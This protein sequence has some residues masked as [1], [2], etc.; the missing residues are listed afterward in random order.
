[1][2]ISTELNKITLV[3]PVASGYA[4]VHTIQKVTTMEVTLEESFITESISS[5]EL[6]T[7]GYYIVSEIKLPDSVSVGNYYISGESIYDTTGTEITVQELLDTDTTGTNI[8]REDNDYFTYYFLE[9]YYINLIKDK[10]MKGIC[11]CNCNNG[12]SSEKL[13]IDTLTMGLEVIKILVEYL[14]YLEA[15]RIIEQLS[16]CSGQIN[17]NCNCYD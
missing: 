17:V 16:V 8:I 7:D 12:K 2:Q 11:S 1:M 14:Q 6:S 13:T 5:Y 10:F 3:S 4:Y 15:E 9:L